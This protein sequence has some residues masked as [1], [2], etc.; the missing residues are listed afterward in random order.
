MA[1]I[2]P[3]P[4]KLTI[5]PTHHGEPIYKNSPITDFRG[6]VWL[7]D[8]IAR[9]PDPEGRSG[10]VMVYPL[11]PNYVLDFDSDSGPNPD[12]NLQPSTL[13]VFNFDVFPGFEAV[14]TITT[15]TPEGNDM[16]EV[17]RIHNILKPGRGE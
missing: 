8:S 15:P 11:P 2:N 5:T 16:K 17:E 12:L 6:D 9:M 4:G 10:K 14:P 1:D 13:R 7:F 3:E